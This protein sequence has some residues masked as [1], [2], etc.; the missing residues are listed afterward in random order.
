MTLVDTVFVGRLGPQ[1]LAGVGLGGMAC[2]L[3][4]GFAL[5][6]LRAGKVLVSQATGAGRR[7]AIGSIIN[8]SALLAVALGVLTAALGYLCAPLLASF[9]ESQ[10]AGNTAVSY[11]QIRVA[12]AP[13]LLLYG[14]LREARFGL[15]DSKSPM[16]A[17]VLANL[18][19]VAFDA[20][21][22]LGL[23]WGVEGAALAT[24]LGHA[25]EAF[26]LG[27]VHLRSEHRHGALRAKWIPELMRL[28]TP[29]G[30][31]FV[32]EIGAFSVL[33][34]LIARISD[35]QMAAHQIALQLTHF[36]FLPAY[37]I[38]E[39]ASV[40]VGQA[41]GAG[42]L[43]WVLPLGRLALRVA[44]VYASL[45]GL[46]LA[47]FARQLGE[48]VTSDQEVL[49]ATAALL[50]VAGL[51]QIAD[52]ANIMA[53]GILRGTGDVRIPAL[54]SVALAWGLTPPLMLVLGYHFELGALGGWFGL[55]LEI[56]LGG[57][58]LWARVLR[59]SWRTAAERSRQLVPERAAPALSEAEHEL[60]PV[61]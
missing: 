2:F 43:E 10:E 39:A 16:V 19:N 17:S 34:V 46:V 29:L 49:V 18:V 25:V 50:G 7:A 9:A 22:I 45:A 37:A 47:A 20:W 48:L 54:W 38:A 51:F 40:L 21:F 24:N 3:V 44:V 59:G 42:R 1:A 8:T 32:M 4:L 35:A 15:G 12:S 53:R 11:F 27:V 36:G 60:D 58:V 55:L 30:L 52:A 6:V 23:H 61:A 57:A 13:L 56:T 26:V 31:Q 33:A 5:G 41:V 28:G 14:A